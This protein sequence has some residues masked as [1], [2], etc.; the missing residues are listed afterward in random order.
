MYRGCLVVTGTEDRPNEGKKR[1]DIRFGRGDGVIRKVLG[2]PPS[3]C[4]GKYLR[5]V[6][7]PRGELARRVFELLGARWKKSSRLGDRS[8]AIHRRILR[9]VETYFAIERRPR[10]IVGQRDGEA[11]EKENNAAAWRQVEAERVARGGGR[12]GRRRRRKMDAKLAR[13]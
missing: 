1:S 11:E 9:I 7:F 8:S 13:Q 12:G 3:G 2:S 5:K 4:A 10:W 6:G